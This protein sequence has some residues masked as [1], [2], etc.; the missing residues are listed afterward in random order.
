MGRDPAGLDH[1]VAKLK[2]TKPKLIVME[3]TGGFEADVA[4]ALAAASLPVCVVNPRQIRD[5]AKAAGRLEKT[6]ALDAA[7]I[8]H[9]AEAIR[10]EPR[11]LPDEAARRLGKPKK[12]ALTALMRKLL[13]VLNAIARDKKPW[14]TA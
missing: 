4:S 1:L 6:D 3:A 8:A 10:P 2:Q 9:F 5:F 11:A 12:L 14:Q 7:A 13:T